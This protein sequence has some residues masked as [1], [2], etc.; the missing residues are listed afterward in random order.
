[1]NVQASHVT[2]M[3]PVLTKKVLLTVNVMLDI[4]EMDLIV[5]V[6]NILFLCLRVLYVSSK[7]FLLVIS[8]I[9]RRHCGI[10]FNHPLSCQCELC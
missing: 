10:M 9:F 5:L 7:Q 3:L 4:L 6:S 1:M 2:P 8:I